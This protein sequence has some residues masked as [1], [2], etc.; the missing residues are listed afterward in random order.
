[1]RNIKTINSSEMAKSSQSLASLGATFYGW[2]VFP[3]GNGGSAALWARVHYSWTGMAGGGTLSF[4][5]V[6]L[7]TSAPAVAEVTRL[8]AHPSV[9]YATAFAAASVNSPL[10]LAGGSASGSDFFEVCAM[11]SGTAVGA[12]IP[13]P[14]FWTIR[15]SNSGTAFSGG[16]LFVDRV[17]LYG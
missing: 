5:A 17:E 1:M 12:I 2:D 3:G 11:S 13:M 6:C 16:T 9:S 14:P 7:P 15:M 10:L 8:L 4:S